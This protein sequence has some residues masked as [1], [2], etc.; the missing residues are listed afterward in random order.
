MKV[1]E[2]IAPPDMSAEFVLETM[3]YAAGR[4]PDRVQ[5]LVRTG[6]EG[7]RSHA[8]VK[9]VCRR[10]PVEVSGGRILVEGHG[11]LDSR[12]LKKVFSPCT[13]VLVFVVTLGPEVDRLV[14]EAENDNMSFAFVLDAVASRM[15]EAAAD[16]MEREL[17][18]ALAPGEG[19]T[20][21]YSP[22]YCD[23]P[24]EG[25]R[26][27][28]SILDGDRIGVSMTGHC[29]MQP[30]KSLSGVIGVGPRHMVAE[31]GNACKFCKREDCD[32]RRD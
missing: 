26:L 23:W 11:S 32:H 2:N 31:A 16:S 4:A 5:S 25:Q 19:A 7:V 14:A 8:L 6:L 10:I 29:L 1:I 15:A 24:V 3:G 12:M 28:F 21:R 22:G 30:R 9:A 18:G 17:T 13:H 27:V 20:L